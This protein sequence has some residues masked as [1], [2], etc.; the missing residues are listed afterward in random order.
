[1]GVFEVYVVSRRTFE[2]RRRLFDV[3]VRV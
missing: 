2:E 3:L 1:V